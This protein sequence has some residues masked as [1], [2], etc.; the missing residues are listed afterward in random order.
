[1]GI[2]NYTEDDVKNCARAF[3]GWT[4]K[5]PI[6]QPPP[7]GRYNWEFE[8]HPDQ[9]DYG[10]KTFLGETG[11]FDGAD[12]IDIIV[13]QPATAQFIAKRLYLFFVSDV[14]QEAIDE[15]AEVYTGL[16]VRHP[17]GHADAVPV[18]RLPLARRVLR[19]GQ[20]PG[21]ARR[22]PDAPGRGLHLPGWG[23][24]EVA[25]ECR[26]MGQDLMNPPSV[27]GWHTARSGSTPASWSSGSTSPPSRS[28]TS[29]SR[30]SEDHRAAA[31][32]RAS[33]RPRRSSTAAST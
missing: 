14:D 18:G 10:E 25:L 27:E 29:P 28:A 12:I 23:I 9:H 5:N 26:Y 8:F 7:Y 13:R 2:G 17:R 33:S 1:M 3:T 31:R 30:A 4:L 15:L 22:R 21:R 20:E 19:Q 32:A 11:N 16:A 24:R 6:P